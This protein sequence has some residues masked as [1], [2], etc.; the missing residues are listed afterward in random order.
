MSA[1]TDR[2]KKV[3]V[4][5]LAEMKQAR[6]KIACLTAYDTSFALQLDQAGVD[7]VLVG[8]S[9]GMVIQGKETTIPVTVDEMLYHTRCVSAGLERALLIA[10]M[11][12]LSFTNEH[13]AVLNAGRFMKE[14]GAHM[15]KLEGGVDQADTVAALNRNG[16]PVCAHLGLQPQY[17]HKIGGYRVQGRNH[18]QAD[19]MLNDALVLQSAGADLMLLECVPVSLADEITRNLDIP[20]IGIGAGP[21]CDGQILVLYDILDISPGTRPKFSRNFLAAAGSIANAVAHYVSAVKSGEFPAAE[22]CFQ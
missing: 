16:I 17:V 4:R 20:V 15:V 22:H 9:L 3:T 1:Q 6:E 10:D 18:E 19:K 13:E 14:G 2:S 8:D 11:P 5:T 12:F 7:V 21:A